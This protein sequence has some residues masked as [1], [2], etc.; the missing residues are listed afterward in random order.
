MYCLLTITQS[1]VVPSLGR[2]CASGQSSDSAHL[3]LEGE[4]W[5]PKTVSVPSLS[6]ILFFYLSLR[7]SLS[8][9]ATFCPVILQHQREPQNNARGQPGI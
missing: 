2:D 5:K 9:S 4:L 1:T 6:P 7:L 8:L 3:F